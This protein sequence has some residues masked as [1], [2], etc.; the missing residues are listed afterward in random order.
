VLLVITDAQKRKVADLM[1]SYR[2]DSADL[3]ADEWNPNNL[4]FV[5]HDQSRHGSSILVNGLIEPD[6]RTHT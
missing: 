3:R 4:Y 6:G 1:R 5:L 2:A